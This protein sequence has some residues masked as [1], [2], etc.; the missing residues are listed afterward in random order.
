[1]RTLLPDPPPAEIQAL[2]A[3]R[4]RLGLDRKDEV[5]EGVLHVV[6]APDFR[7][8]L[9]AQQLAEL[10]GPPARD[11]GLLPAMG[12][13][14]LGDSTADFRVPN[15]GLHRPGTAGTWL[16]T[17]ALVVEILSPGDE[18]WQKLPF[19][20]SHGVDEL[21]IVDPEKCEVHWLALA[22]AAYQ[23]LERSG[24]IELGPEALTQQIDWP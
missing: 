24:L 3:R 20:A 1:M 9:I 12:E 21:L 4:K 2:L 5:W 19:Y 23:P 11:A 17:A 10:I 8:A 22:G 13:F 7:H 18:T 16:P 14:N 6:P 15:G